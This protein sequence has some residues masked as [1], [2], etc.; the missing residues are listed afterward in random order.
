MS[1]AL[2]GS[3]K[4]ADA[5]ERFCKA[6]YFR[7]PVIASRARLAARCTARSR[8]KSRAAAFAFGENPASVEE[9]TLN[10]NRSVGG[11]SPELQ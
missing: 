6:S 10:W 9:K 2:E 11:A 5:P 1:S 8:D 3:R 4:P 7:V